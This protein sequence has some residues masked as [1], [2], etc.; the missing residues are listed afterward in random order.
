MGYYRR[1]QDGPVF[2]FIMT[3]LDAIGCWL[4]GIIV[5]GIA[6]SNARKGNWEVAILAAVLGTPWLIWLVILVYINH[7]NKQHD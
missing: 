6:L 7:K 5:L 1:K 3:W 4:P 2:A